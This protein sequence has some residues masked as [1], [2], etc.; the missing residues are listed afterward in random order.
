MRTPSRENGNKTVS[1]QTSSER[2]DDV[3]PAHVQRKQSTES[4]LSDYEDDVGKTTTL[5]KKKKKKKR[6]QK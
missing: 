3:T 5:K 1:R 2:T 4:R 6:R